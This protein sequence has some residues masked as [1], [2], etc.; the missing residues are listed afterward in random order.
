MSARATAPRVATLA[1]RPKRRLPTVPAAQ[2]S[3]ADSVATFEL[4]E[5]PREVSRYLAAV[6]VYRAAGSAPTW[7]AESDELVGVDRG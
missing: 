5:L 2:V 6:D 4:N 1:I 7:R 3:L